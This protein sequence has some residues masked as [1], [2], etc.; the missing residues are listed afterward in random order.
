MA[1]YHNLWLKLKGSSSVKALQSERETRG[2]ESS[3]PRKMTV[4]SR[5]DYVNLLYLFQVVELIT[6]KGTNKTARGVNERHHRHA[7]MRRNTFH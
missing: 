1:D 2:K 4:S 3:W 7:S 5:S 6:N